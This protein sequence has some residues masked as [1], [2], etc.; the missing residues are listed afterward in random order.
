MARARASVTMQNGPHGFSGTFRALRYQ[1][2]MGVFLEVMGDLPPQDLR[3]TTHS[4]N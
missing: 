2:T 3:T 1:E 4:L